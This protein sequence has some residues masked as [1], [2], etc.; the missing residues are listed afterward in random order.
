MKLYGVTMSPFVQ[1][2]LLAGRIKGHEIAL[3]PPM[4]G[5]FRSLEMLAVSPLGRIPVLDD[6]G[7][8]LCESDAIIQYLDETLPGP[9]L[10]ADTPRDRAKARC[11][12]ELAGLELAGGLRPAMICKVFKVADLPQLFDFG[13]AQ[14][15]N[16]LGAIEKVR[17]PAHPYAWGD[18]PGIAD[19][20]LTPLLSLM[21]LIA[22]IAEFGTPLDKTPGLA[23]YY[24]RARTD[25][26]LGRTIDEMREGFRHLTQ[27]QP[28]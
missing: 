25:P 9:S 17:D 16:G 22:P 1:R 2:V 7:W 13:V 15:T 18:R 8:T 10:L 14:F 3:E 12:T 24:E 6:D 5:N 26:L 11:I 21:E 19:C 4:G 23:A 20:V 27:P 28:A